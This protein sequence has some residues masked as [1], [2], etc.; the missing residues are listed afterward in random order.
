MLYQMRVGYPWR[1]LSEAFRCWNS[2]YKRFSAWS[3]SGKWV[4]VFKA[5][6]IE[7]GLGKGEEENG[8]L[9]M[10]ATLKRISIVQVQ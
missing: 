5:L 8:N 6:I 7:P 3:L 4:R 10:A 9:L 1:D 2:I